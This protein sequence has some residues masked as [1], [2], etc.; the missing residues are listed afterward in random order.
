M[1][2]GLPG[3]PRRGGAGGDVYRKTGYSGFSNPELAERLRREGVSQLV[4]AGIKTDLCVESTV[5]A[6]FDLGFETFVPADAAATGS[7]ER[8]VAALRGLARG[9]STVRSAS[10]LLR[11]WNGGAK[12]AKIKG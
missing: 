6:A 5:R 11:P 7:E 12:T 3:S 4:V 9:F 10:E 2:G 1:R 8:H